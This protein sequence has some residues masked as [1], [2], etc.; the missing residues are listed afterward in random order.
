MKRLLNQFKEKIY[1]D[2]LK[3]VILYG[4]LYAI[5]FGILAGALQFVAYSFLGIGF[6]LLIYLV[7][8]MIGREIKNRIFNY[9]ILYSVIG[10][11]FFI[12]GFFLYNIS[13]WSFVSHNVSIGFNFVFSAMG[14]KYSVFE[15]LN[16]NT[17]NG[18]NIFYNIIDIILI[19][20]CFITVWRMPESKK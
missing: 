9:H 4:G 3:R 10:V 13:L 11:L 15:F 19:V 20:Y 5:V 14:M 12:I 17:Y 1:T 8:Y 6:S 16:F 2:D 18:I 7:A